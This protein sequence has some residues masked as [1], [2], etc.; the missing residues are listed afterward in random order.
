MNVRADAEDSC[1][2]ASPDPSAMGVSSSVF[3]STVGLSVGLGVGFFVGFLVGF[4]VG[5]FVGGS[6]GRVPL[7]GHSFDE[8]VAPK[9]ATP[10]MDCDLLTH[11]EYL[12]VQSVLHTFSVFPS[13]V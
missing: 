8:H 6:H 11:S 4:L 3:T 10:V 5:L 2:A 7:F 13:H 1:F 9:F 12:G